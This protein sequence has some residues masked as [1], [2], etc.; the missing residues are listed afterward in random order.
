MAVLAFAGIH[1]DIVYPFDNW[2]TRIPAFLPMGLYGLQIMFA[3]FLLILTI[4]L[5]TSFKKC[6]EGKCLNWFKTTLGVYVVVAFIEML[7]RFIRGVALEDY[8]RCVEVFL[9]G[10]FQTTFNG[11][12]WIITNNICNGPREL[13]V[14][15]Q[16]V[17]LS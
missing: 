15:G 8:Q 4:V 7:V 17:S 10:F 1:R 3:L 14:S 9:T 16:T 5:L 12:F 2:E 13:T 11:F 6:T